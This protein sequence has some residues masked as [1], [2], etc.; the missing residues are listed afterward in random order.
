MTILKGPLQGLGSDMTPLVLVPTGGWFP[1]CIGLV[2]TL[3]SETCIINVSGMYFWNT[4]PNTQAVP[5]GRLMV[6]SYQCIVEGR[7][8]RLASI[9]YARHPCILDIVSVEYN[10]NTQRQYSL[11]IGTNI[12]KQYTAG[13]APIHAS[14]HWRIRFRAS[15]N[16]P[17]QYMTECAPIHDSR[18]SQ[19]H[20]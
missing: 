18:H 17:K 6:G 2:S 20:F 10:G 12:P 1:P 9:V 15:T 3:Y 19:M 4:C 14:R 8:A 5:R 11:C 13:C 16:I 7:R